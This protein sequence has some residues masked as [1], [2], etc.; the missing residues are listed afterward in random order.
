A[1]ITA[2]PAVRSEKVSTGSSRDIPVLGQELVYGGKAEG[3]ETSSQL[4]DRDTELLH[5]RKEAYGPRKHTRA[6]EGVKHNVFQRTSQKDKSLVKNQSIFLE[7]QEELAQKKDNSPV[8]APQASTSTKYREASPKEQ[9]EGPAQMEQDLPEE[10]S[11]C[12]PK[13]EHKHDSQ[14]P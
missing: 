9:P 1:D 12:D 3:G 11:A 6:S 13:P 2:I 5:S 10:L 7:Y 14:I 8:E 4:V